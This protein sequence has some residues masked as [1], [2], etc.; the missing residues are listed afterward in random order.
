MREEIKF[1]VYFEGG[2]KMLAN[3]W[4][5]GGKEKGVHISDMVLVR[6]NSVTAR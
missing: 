5:R 2:F 4:I 3:S 6:T 1:Q